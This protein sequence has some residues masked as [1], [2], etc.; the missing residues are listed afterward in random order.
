L[1]EGR[2]FTN[3]ESLKDL[4]Y[5]LKMKKMPK[6]HWFDNLGWE[7]VENIHDVV[8]ERTKE[9]IKESPF[10]A[11]Y[12]DEVPTSNMN[13]WNFIQGYVLENLRQIPILLNLERVTNGVN[14]ENIYNV[15]L[16]TLLILGGAYII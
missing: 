4:F 10:I 16:Q 2:P 11:L 14:I 1:K 7:M 6:K 5:F 12:V 15:M 3:Y 9:V 8:L 13:Y